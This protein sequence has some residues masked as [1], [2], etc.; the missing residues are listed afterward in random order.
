MTDYIYVDSITGQ[1]LTIEIDSILDLDF[2]PGFYL[3]PTN[4]PPDDDRM[5]WDFS[6]NVWFW[7]KF[8]LIREAANLQLLDDTTGTFVWNTVTHYTAEFQQFPWTE[9][10]TQAIREDKA[11]SRSVIFGDGSTTILTNAQIVN[12]FEIFSNYIQGT[13]DIFNSAVTLINNNTITTLSQLNSYWASTRSGYTT[14]RVTATDNED[15]YNLIVGGTIHNNTGSTNSGTRAIVTSTTSANGFR[16]STTHPVTYAKYNIT[17][18]ISPTLLTSASRTVAAYV[19]P[20]NSTTSG[21][22]VKYD[23]ISISLPGGVA[24]TNTTVIQTLILNDIPTGYWI[25]LLETST[26]TGSSS[27]NSFIEKY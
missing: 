25:R 16:L 11:N 9:V 20:T 14:S 21:D 13:R 19:A 3:V 2:Y 5:Y 18:T 10:F 22:W 6:N 15:L 27:I 8:V 12:L 23:T 17:L 26:G 7:P 4:T 24:L 1:L